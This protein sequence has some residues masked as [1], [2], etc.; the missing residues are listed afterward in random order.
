ML[1]IS[2]TVLL[3]FSAIGCG[4]LA[5]LYFAFSAFIMTALG[6][7]EQ[8]AGIAAMN[9]INVAIVQSLFLPVV[10]SVSFE[11]IRLAETLRPDVV[12]VIKPTRVARKSS[13]WPD[14]PP[15]D[16]AAGKRAKWRFVNR[17]SGTK[18]WY[19]R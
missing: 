7:I 18:E 8:T 10:A 11:V 17:S 5:G 3:W 19:C 9:A 14:A 16:C 1:Q 13:D 4:L 12:P 6:R 15:P 2:V